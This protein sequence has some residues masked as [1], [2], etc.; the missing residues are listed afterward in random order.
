V[1]WLY[2]KR[3][4]LPSIDVVML[5]QSIEKKR[6]EF[7][8]PPPPIVSL[9]DTDVEKPDLLASDVTDLGDNRQYLTLQDPLFEAL[10]RVKEEN[11]GV[12]PRAL[13]A[14][15]VSEE[16]VLNKLAQCLSGT[17]SPT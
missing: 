11:K 10:V 4:L 7:L 15:L 3:S 9:I 1:L 6:I 12:F 16:R 2:V 8:K 5:F 17:H 14:T 13:L